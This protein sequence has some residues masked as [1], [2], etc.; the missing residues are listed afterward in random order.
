M[1]DLGCCLT[2]YAVYKVA[3]LYAASAD[4]ASKA[5]STVKTA[6]TKQKEPESNGSK[7]W[8]V[9][10][11]PESVEP[12]S[13]PHT[14]IAVGGDTQHHIQNVSGTDGNTNGNAYGH[15]GGHGVYDE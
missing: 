4:G 1:G 13:A 3:T 12:Q 15:N 9:S 2:S 8:S 7:T 11:A 10:P 5:E 14:V 6:A